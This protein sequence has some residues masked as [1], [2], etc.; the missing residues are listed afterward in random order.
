MSDSDG[1]I[2]VNVKVRYGHLLCWAALASLI[3]GII[4]LAGERPDEDKLGDC[5]DNAWEMYNANLSFFIM[6]TVILFTGIY[7]FI[8]NHKVEDPLALIIWGASVVVTCVGLCI[9]YLVIFG[10]SI[11]CYGD[12]WK[13]MPLTVIYFSHVIP[14][15]IA[16]ALFLT[17]GLGLV[18]TINCCAFR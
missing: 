11:D 17:L 4:A 7:V 3:I 16:M 6:E 18:A 14:G 13:H 8:S 1:I 9:W 5:F 12:I 15:A 2:E 10:Q